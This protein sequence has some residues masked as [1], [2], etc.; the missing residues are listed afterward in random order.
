ME[1]YSDTLISVMTYILLDIGKVEK[2]VMDR[3]T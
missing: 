2:K 1:S 3:Q